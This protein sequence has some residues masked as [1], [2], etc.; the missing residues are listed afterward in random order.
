MLAVPSAAMAASPGYSL[1][2]GFSPDPTTVGQPGCFGQWR[3]EAAQSIN[4]GN[5]EG[6]ETAGDYLSTPGWR[7]RRQQ[8]P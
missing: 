5:L 8:R 3:S 7:Q 1:G 2:D 4:A 6:F